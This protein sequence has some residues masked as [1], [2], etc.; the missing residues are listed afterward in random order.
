M[1]LF[2]VGVAVVLLSGCNRTPYSSPTAPRD[3]NAYAKAISPAA[4]GAVDLTAF[5]QATV[6]EEGSTLVLTMPVKT[7][8]ERGDGFSHVFK[9][10][11]KGERIK[12]DGAVFEL[13]ALS[14]SPLPGSATNE[15][16]RVPL[17]FYDL[18]GKPLSKDELTAMGFTKW[19]LTE[20]DDGYDYYGELFPKIKVWFGSK[21]QPPGYF[22][23]VGL[24]DAQTKHRLVSG[25]GYS[26]VRSNSVGYAEFR[27]R[28]WHAP[29]MELLVDLELDGKTV[30]ETNIE[31]GIT[32]PVAGGALR[33][34]GVWEGD[35]SSTSSGDGSTPGMQTSRIRFQTRENQTNATALF[36]AE[37]S[38]LAVHIELLDEHGR[39]L[40]GAGGGT[41]G[42]LREV[43]FRGLPEEAKR[44]RLTVFTNHYLILVELPPIPALATATGGLNL[45]ETIIPL[46]KVDREYELRDMIGDLTQ[47]RFQHP[48]GG[49]QL[50]TNL[51]PVTLT[52][53]TPGDLLTFY[54]RN[55]TNMN[56]V[57]VDEKKQEIRVEPTLYEKAKRWVKQKLRL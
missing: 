52:N 57:V 17:H 40:P 2:F 33:F 32:V 22:S 56:T 50:P 34:L 54:R 18:A 53:V 30:L 13:I 14:L 20:Y 27:P 43:G 24:F 36:L 45:F 38:G 21:D 44:M 42:N 7:L 16:K 9:H 29:P 3:T 37:P 49:N 39:E 55:M 28:A 19:Q 35:V 51:F 23:P 31:E 47:M 1:R 8:Q 48:R 11:H 12:G 15:Q 5:D 26:Q 41:S 10:L 6:S 4:P 25:Y 46:V